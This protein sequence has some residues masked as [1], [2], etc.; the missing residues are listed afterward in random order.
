MKGL[1]SLIAIF[2]LL[3]VFVCFGIK[4]VGTLFLLVVAY[5]FPKKL[6]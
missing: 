5:A 3:Y 1:L 4:G 2:I 6:L